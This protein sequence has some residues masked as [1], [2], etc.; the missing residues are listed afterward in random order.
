MRYPDWKLR[1]IDYVGVCANLPF[2]YGQHDCALFAAGAVDA[3][4]GIDL[5]ADWRG[6][7]ST[8]KSGLRAIKRAGYADHLA[9]ASA[10][11]EAIA[12]AFAAPGDLAVIDG[13]EGAVLGVVQGEGIYV[14][15]LSG[16]GTLPLTYARSAFRVT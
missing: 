3:M 14:L 9:F 1:L 4:T 11:F 8:L 7:Y 15:A 2:E 6:Q 5:A 12:I 16:L 10:H 13:P